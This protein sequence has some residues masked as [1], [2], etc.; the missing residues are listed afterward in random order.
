MFHETIG[1]SV[2][3]VR[4]SEKRT[5]QSTVGGRSPETLSW[6]IKR[7]AGSHP[8]ER[9]SGDLPRALVHTGKAKSFSTGHCLPNVRPCL[10]P[11]LCWDG[12]LRSALFPA[13][14]R[15]QTRPGWSR[16][17]GSVEPMRD[18]PYK[19]RRIK[20]ELFQFRPAAWFQVLRVPSR[21]VKEIV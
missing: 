16:T 19:A 5:L 18:S 15:P 6:G 1:F 13:K 4:A 20:S 17:L 2:P 14:D 9:V 7:T 10:R 12:S 11:V 21:W 8:Q 3:I